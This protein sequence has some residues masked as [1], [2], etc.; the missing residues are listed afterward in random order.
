MLGLGGIGTFF[1]VGGGINASQTALGLE[2]IRNGSSVGI[3]ASQVEL[4]LQSDINMMLANMMAAS[5]ARG[6]GILSWLMKDALRKKGFN[7]ITGNVKNPLSSKLSRAQER[8]IKKM[9]NVIEN[10]LKEHDFS[11]TLRDLKGDPVPNKK[12]GGFWDH[13]TEMIQSYNSLKGGERKLKD[14]LKNPNLDLEVRKYIENKLKTLQI[15]I[16]RIEDLFRPFG[17]VK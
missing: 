13:K 3:A 17:G 8:N 7:V 14:S 12:T 1:A 4:M 6:N 11:G 9:D 16:K 10:N 2:R 5:A 15:Q